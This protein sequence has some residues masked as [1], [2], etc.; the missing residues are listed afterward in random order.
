MVLS[1]PSPSINKSLIGPTFVPFGPWGTG[2]CPSGPPVKVSYLYKPTAMLPTLCA[3]D[4]IT[5]K[6]IASL[7]R[8]HKVSRPLHQ[9][10]AETSGFVYLILYVPSTIFHLY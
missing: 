4:A 2:P 10:I 7:K 1:L 5:N 8:K 9:F 3:P 6:I